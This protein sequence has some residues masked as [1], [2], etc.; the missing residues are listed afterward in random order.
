[1]SQTR[2]ELLAAS[3]DLHNELNLNHGS[4]TR[5]RIHTD[6]KVGVGTATPSTLFTVKSTSPSSTGS[7]LVQNGTY[8]SNQD[9][10]FLIAGSNSWTGAATNWGTYGFQFKVKSD[11][12][13]VARIAI[14]SSH[15]GSAIEGISIETQGFVGLNVTNPTERLD[16]DGNI[17]ITG[18]VDGRD[19][20]VDGA[21]LDGIAAG[22]EVNVATDLS[23]TPASR[24]I[25]SSTGTDATLPLVAAA[26]NPG[27][28][29]GA[30]KTKLDGISAGAEVNVQ[31]DWNA[32][33]GDAFIANKPT[34]PTNNNQL[35]NGAGY[36]T[37][38]D[39]GDAATLDGIDSANFLRSDQED[40]ATIINIGG[41]IAPTSSA[42]LQVYGFSRMGPI[43][44]AAGT[45]NASTFST[46]NERWIMNDGSHLYASTSSTAYNNKIWTDGNHGPGS[47]L[48]ADTVDGVEGVRIVYGTNQSGSNAASTTQ[49]LS[50]AAQWKSGFWD[51]NGASWTPNTGW[52]WGATFA[53][54][55]NS[56][57]YN[58]SGQLIFENGSAGD[59]LYARTILNGSAS[60]WSKLWSTGNDGAGSGLDADLL[61][62]QQGSYYLDYNNLTNVP[63]G[64]GSNA[65][66][67][68]NLDSTQFLR[69]DQSDTFTGTLSIVGSINNSSTGGSSGAILGNLEV[70]YGAAYNSISAQSNNDLHL[71]YNST[72]TVYVGSSNTVWHAGNDGSG[73]GLDADTVD[74]IN[75][76]SFVR[77]DTTNNGDIS[78]PTTNAPFSSHSHTSLAP[79]SLRLWDS[80]NAGGPTT[81]GTVLDMYGRSSH[82]RHQLNFFQQD[83]KFRSGWYGNNNW[84]G[85]DTLWHTGNDG[86]GSGL[87]ADTV[88]GIQASSFLRSDASDTGTGYIKLTGGSKIT[89]QGGTDGGTNHGLMMWTDTDTNWGIY[90][91]QAGA[92]KSLAGNTAVSSINGRSSHHIRFRVANGT[93]QGFVWE[94]SGESCLMSLT[95]DTGHLYTKGNIYA[96][97][98]TSNLVWHSGNDG[99]GSGLDA[100]TVDGI[101]AANFVRSDTSDTMSGNLTVDNGTSTTVSVKCDNGGNAI[102]RAGGDSQGTGAFEVTQDNGQHGGGI[103]Y[104]GDGTPG[105]A[106]GETSDHVT[107]Y[108]IASGT[109]TEVFHYPYNS[110]VVN[111]NDTATMAGGTVWHSA[112]DGS[113]S[114]LDADTVDG[115]NSASFLRSDTT[116]SFS[117]DITFSSYLISNARDKGLFGIY[118]SYKTDQ[119]WSM[120]TS[121]RNSSTGASFGNLYGLAYKHTNNTTGGTMGG[122]HQVVWCN[123][124]TPRGAIGYNYVWHTSG[125]RV[126]SN[127]VW[128]AGN[129][130]SGSGLDADNLD[131]YTWT[132]G[133]NAK[134]SRLEF[135]GVGGN[136]GNGVHDY[137]IYQE[138]GSWSS[139]YPDLVIGYHTGVKIGGHTSYNGTRFYSDAPGRSGASELFSVGNGDTNVRVTNNLYIGG[140]TAWHAGNDGS[141]SG[142]DADLLD[143][144]HGSNYL[145]FN[146]N[147]YYQASNWID[148]G[149]SNG[150][151]LYWSSGTGVGWHFYPTTSARMVMRSGDTSVSEIDF[152]TAG[153]TRA[154][155]YVNNSGQIGF[156]NA[157]HNWSFKCDSSGNVTATGNVTAYSDIRLKS[158]IEPITNALDKVSQINGVTFTRVDSG[159]R[160]VGVIAQDVEK[161]LPEAVRDGEEYKS[162]AYGNMVGLLVEAVKELTARVEEL[163]EELKAR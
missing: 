18:T 78:F 15:G 92:S 139:P 16:I 29:T 79:M 69:S 9:Y 81:Y 140:S 44:L 112:N 146:G 113:G 52:W 42:K 6:G 143:G 105:F 41:E 95:S 19:V 48:N 94:N 152:Q 62:G 46:T 37:S 141:G 59:G 27:L 122:G 107:F 65:D 34:I 147:S 4:N 31:A 127:T 74:G 153:T 73:S 80:Y 125:M 82:S 135:T 12:G 85:W 123:N 159:E 111:F 77:L 86:S 163:E 66:T 71:N 56:S 156:L 55:S 60:G 64:G 39:G 61:D 142:L 137:A 28:M 157:S 126:G 115:I 138:G 47:G 120:G 144:Y 99:S 131:G 133:T 68:D 1:M 117:G 3:V 21:K 161:V 134:F 100:D 75:A 7:I 96:G 53:H 121:Y 49:T 128:H 70:G 50:E 35:T 36:I 97:N 102:V 119:I 101:Q 2:V 88:D 155:L 158:D 118:D 83:I 129:D 24:V 132:S 57:S 124:G 160:Q 116:D 45:S 162:V 33:S 149:P 30:D 145:G 43:M 17:K 38:A 11:S 51:I 67:L 91:S 58:Y 136:S 148:F 109:R 32:T 13:G 14:E 154:Y 108:R 72:G 8:A 110:N 90:M 103:S 26:G 63:A 76:A 54:R 5:L 25:S 151:G 98:S 150:D 93:T 10:P 106:S 87:D 130:G 104:N 84:T 22:A 40:Q 23:Y 89:V 114:G 20:S